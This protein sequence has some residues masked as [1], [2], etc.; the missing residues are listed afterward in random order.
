[1]T[2]Y[3]IGAGCG[4]KGLLTSH[5]AEIIDKCGTVIGPERL[6]EKYADEKKVFF[7]YKPENIKNIIDRQN[8][9][10]AVLMS[11]DTGIFSGT[12]KLLSVLDGYDVEVIPGIS[13]VSYFSSKINIPWQEWKIISIH[14][15]KSNVIGHIRENKYTF[16]FLNNTDDI[17]NICGKLVNYGMGNVYVYAG[18]NLSY[19]DEK[20]FEGYAEDINCGEKTGLAVALFINENCK[21]VY[22]EIKDSEFI[23]GNVPM[24]KSEIRTLSVSKLGLDNNSVLYDV[25]AGTGS[26]S[27]VAALLCPDIKVYAIEKNMDAVELIKKNKI[28]FC[29]DNI[30]IV[31]GEASVALDYI[32]ENPTHVFIG[33]SGGR[34]SDIVSKIVNKN[35]TAR[36]VVNAVTPETLSETLKV[37][38][39]Y[40]M[41]PD[42]VQ[43]FAA[44]GEKV[45]NST[46]MKALNPVYIISF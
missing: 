1:M 41:V 29:T 12:K 3:I 40:N 10:T 32:A 14:G 25:G 31:Q 27:V 20:I 36:F 44:K 15:R 16:V 6:A 9:D 17:K 2:V 35:E 11:G 45:G 5:S 26:V 18:I 13:S 8:E 34:M 33:G 23:R 42:I 19:S 30:E 39:M 28:K 43:I 38:E 22:G 7:E 21:K 46:I 24:T 4:D 37:C